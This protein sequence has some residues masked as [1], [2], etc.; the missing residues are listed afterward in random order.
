VTVGDSPMPT[1]PESVWTSTITDTHGVR[2]I[3]SRDDGCARVNGTATIVD[4][5][6]V[7]FK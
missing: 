3:T 1:S 5:K 7:I 2:P 6:S 4:L